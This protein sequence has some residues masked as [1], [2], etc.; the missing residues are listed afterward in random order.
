ME[1]LYT[2]Y[3]Y[4]LLGFAFGFTQPTSD[5]CWVSRRDV[6]WNVSTQP[7]TTSPNLRLNWIIGAIDHKVRSA[8][9]IDRAVHWLT[10]HDH[11]A[12]PS[13]SPTD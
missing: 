6:P 12:I 9:P 3:D 7:T 2:T 1:R 13:Y 8:F 11:S 5:W 10:D 4:A